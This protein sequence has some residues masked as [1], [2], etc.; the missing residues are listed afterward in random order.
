MSVVSFE[1]IMC[2]FLEGSTNGILVQALADSWWDTTHTFHIAGRGM[3]VTPHDFHQMTNLR[4]DGPIINLESD[5]GIQLGINLLG[6]KYLSK[7]ICYFDLERD[8]M[9]LS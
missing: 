4:F 6:Q 2:L 1:P 5:L 9:P 3:T 7:H 8:Y